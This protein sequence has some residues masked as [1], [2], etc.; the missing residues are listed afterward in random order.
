[1]TYILLV[2]EFFKI[3]LLAIG[4]GL[5]TVPFLFD[6]ADKYDWFSKQ[7]LAD[8][9]AISESTPGPIGVNMA[10]FAGFN[11]GGIGGGILATL[12]LVLPS[13]IIMIIIAKVMGKYSCNI[14]VKDVLNGI[15]PAVLAMILFAGLDLG[16]IVIVGNTEILFLAVIIAMMRIWKK[17]P[18]YYLCLSGVLGILLK[19]L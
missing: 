5:V 13:V 19:T 14:R 10:T 18:I 16:K 1:M 12:S 2:W 8:M 17:S 9:I 15:R 6:L 7:E 3:G 11:A 4:G